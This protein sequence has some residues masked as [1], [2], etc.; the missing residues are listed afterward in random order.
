M[1][2]TKNTSKKNYFQEEDICLVDACDFLQKLNKY[3]ET[4]DRWKH[5]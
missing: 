5:K 4:V 2:F 3:I 1:C